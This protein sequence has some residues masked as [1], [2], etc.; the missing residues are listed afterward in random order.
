VH[1]GCFGRVEPEFALKCVP[2]SMHRSGGRYENP[3]P[4]RL[5][6]DL[7][8]IGS[9]L[10]GRSWLGAESF[11][12]VLSQNRLHL[13]WICDA[14][15]KCV[16]PCSTTE[17]DKNLSNDCLCIWSQDS[18]GPKQRSIIDSRSYSA[19]GDATDFA[20]RRSSKADRRNQERLPH[21]SIA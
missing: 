13:P 10:R 8:C 9:A 11:T 16:Y 7:L 19:P 20:D 1:T 14:F 3:Y 2:G 12:M 15:R 4:V 17:I 21:F 18:K 5:N 6:I